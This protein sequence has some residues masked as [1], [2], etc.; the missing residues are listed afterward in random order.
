MAKKQ[1]KTGFG[2][3]KYPKN[4]STT[5]V[6]KTSEKKYVDETLNT[7]QEQIENLKFKA[8][9]AEQND[10]IFE[11]KK[12]QY[13]KA[14]DG[15]KT[16]EDQ[17]L[18]VKESTNLFDDRIGGLETNFG[19]L[20]NQVLSVAE[21]ANT[22]TDNLQAL[23]QQVGINTTAIAQLQENGGG[24]SDET[25]AAINA[26]SEQTNQN[27][28]DIELLHEDLQ[29]FT[30]KVDEIEQRSFN[31]EINHLNL[32]AQIDSNY[33][34]YK[35]LKEE[36]DTNTQKIEAL[37]SEDTSTTELDLIDL[38]NRVDEQQTQIE[39]LQA[40]QDINT[41]NIASWLE[42][43]NKYGTL[44]DVHYEP[45][46]Y[47]DYPAG[48]IFQT[49]ACFEKMANISATST[50][51]GPVANFLAE[52]GAEGK[53]NYDIEVVSANDNVDAL[54]NIYLNDV[55]I[56][57]QTL[58]LPQGTTKLSSTLFDIALNTT[59]KQNKVHATIKMAKTNQ[60]TLKGVK[61]ELF[62]AN[63][64]IIPL[65][66]NYNVEYA[67]GKYYISDCSS[68]TAH[69]A[70]V[71][72]ENLSRIDRLTFDD[73]GYEA[74][75]FF[76]GFSAKEYSG[77]Y[78]YDAPAYVCM[79]GNTSA[80][81]IVPQTGAQKALN[82]STN[83]DWLPNNTTAVRYVTSNTSGVV[84]YINVNL[85]AGTVGQG[86]GSSKAQ[87]IVRLNAA[88]TFEAPNGYLTGLTF[89]AV[90]AEGE[91]YVTNRSKTTDANN[92]NLGYGTVAKMYYTYITSSSIFGAKVF[93]KRY[94][95][96]VEYDLSYTSSGF[97]INSITEL[98]SYDDF[99][100]GANND[101]FIV[102]NGKLTYHVFPSQTN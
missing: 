6:L 67:A 83:F 74:Q 99:F 59:S 41:A 91:V 38:T 69:L 9:T 81:I 77:S 12:T 101:Y 86:S 66:T 18:E 3:T 84:K 1:T 80:N 50:L 34:F 93:V 98:G 92:I 36:V 40:Q 54:F 21:Q 73:L 35:W 11:L 7:Q 30:D 58:V 56:F 46:S 28:A 53:L 47:S 100:Y 27:T 4:K 19:E 24:T 57:E 55:S 71:E 8:Q 14:L 25:T 75:A 49:Y 70:V 96:I 78:V 87:K 29:A 39:A 60:V 76:I 20:D 5:I 2:E 88:K 61:F 10:K 62:A 22:N 44:D 63:A 37:Q 85:E 97:T 43:K 64:D 68:G 15:Y 13:D 32:Q 94:D 31:T 95:K 82:T 33:K 52:I 79:T 45:K 17:L 16:F 42:Y 48:T 65:A 89:A 23:E 90:T 72:K 102:R 51:T 26:L